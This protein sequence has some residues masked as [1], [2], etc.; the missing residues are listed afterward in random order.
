MLEGKQTKKNP[1]KPQEQKYPSYTSSKDS[2]GLVF[3]GQYI[4]VWILPAYAEA[5]SI[6]WSYCCWILE[7]AWIFTSAM[8]KKWQQKSL[9]ALLIQQRN[10]TL[11]IQ[12]PCNELCT[13]SPF[14]INFYFAS[15]F[16]LSFSPQSWHNQC[17]CDIQSHDHEVLKLFCCLTLKTTTHTWDIFVSN[18]C[19]TFLVCVFF[20]VWGFFTFKLIEYPQ[21]P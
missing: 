7:F 21:N 1:K 9:F 11:I 14:I 5:N 8:N 6:S 16:D 2:Q 20:R 12:K 19:L 17:S 10:K 13:S 3:K 18:D 15:G 4:W